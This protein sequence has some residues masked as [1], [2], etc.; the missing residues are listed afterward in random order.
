MQDITVLKSIKETTIRESKPTPPMKQPA[1]VWQFVLSISTT[2]AAIVTGAMMLSSMYTNHEER[3]KHLEEF[4]TEMKSDIKEIR[5]D[6]EK[7]LIL[8]QNKQDRK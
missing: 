6:Q 3:I 1:Q 4:K 5:D 8:L 7:I 2:V